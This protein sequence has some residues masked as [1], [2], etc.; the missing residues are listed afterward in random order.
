MSPFNASRTLRSGLRAALTAG[1]LLLAACGGGGGGGAAPAPPAPSNLSYPGPQTYTVGTAITP[2][3]P[4]VT[5]TVTGWSVAP[6][7]PGGLTL[8][9]SNGQISGTPTTPAA[10]ATY[11]VTAQNA[12]G[13][14]SA[15]VSITVNAATTAVLQPGG[16]TTIAVGQG[17]NLY[18]Q[19]QVGGAPFPNYVDANQVTWSSSAPAR[20]AVNANGIVT[21]ISEGSATITAQYQSFSLTLAVQVSGAFAT[22]T[23]TVTGQGT[24]RYTLYTPPA[25]SGPRPLLLS[26]HG[27]GGSA[28]L[29]AAMTQMVKVAQAQG[30]RVAFLEGTGLIQTFNGGACCGSAQ[31]QNVDDVAYVNAV[32]DDLIARDPVDT[33][34]VYSSG[35]SNGGIMSHRLA[36]AIAGRIAG[37]AAVGGASGQ[38]DRTGTQYYACNPSRPVPVLQ[39]HAVNDRNYPYA[40][41]PGDGL[42]G[43]DYYGVEDTVRDWRVRNNVTDQAVPENVTATTRCLRYAAPADAGRPSAAVTLCRVDPPDV[44][45]PVNRIVY[46]GGHS[47]PGGV[48]SPSANSDVPLADFDASAYLWRFLNP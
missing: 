28:Q 7:L 14:T 27:G 9:T 17:I 37:I 41:G 30:F 18:F 3:Q 26:L 31:T 1:L 21:G 20:A 19:Q 44:Y 32:L 47:W 33:A 10:T 38:F 13:S 39:I 16:N 6:A 40:G 15:G 29:Q 12:G 23:L 43:T 8:N 5:G 22:R 42:S 4:T 24:R 46:G 11:T 35:F 25:T 34:R 45:D 36:C 48:R 2:L